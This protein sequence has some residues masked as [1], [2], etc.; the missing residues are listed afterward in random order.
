MRHRGRREDESWTRWRELPRAGLEMV[1]L[2]LGSVAGRAESRAES[3]DVD[4]EEKVSDE[5]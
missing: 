1:F 2:P 3:A 5:G 4:A